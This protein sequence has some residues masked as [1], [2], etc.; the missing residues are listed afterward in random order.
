MEWTENKGPSRGPVVKNPGTVL[1]ITGYSGSGKTT[2]AREATSLLR[3][4]GYPTVFLDGDD[5]RAI[6]RNQWGYTKAERIELAQIYLRFCSY[7]A[8]Q[9]VNV[10]L[11]AAAMYQTVFDWFRVHIPNAILIYLDVPLS[12][13][14]RRD[15]QTK[16]LYETLFAQQ[17]GYDEPRDAMR[18]ANYGRTRP[19]DAARSILENFLATRVRVGTAATNDAYWDGVYR[20]TDRVP[21]PSPFAVFVSDNY[22]TS[23]GSLLE[24]GCGNG[25]D[26]AYFAQK[27]HSILGIDTSQEAIDLCRRLHGRLGARFEQGAADDVTGKMGASRFAAVYCRFVIHVMTSPEEAAFLIAAHELLESD[28]LLLIECRSINDTLKL[29]GDVISPTERIHGHYRRFIVK[30]ELERSLLLLGFRIEYAAEGKGFAIHGSEDP[31]IIRVI[32]RKVA[33]K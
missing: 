20:Q 24:V 13:R 11:S 33:T 26:S 9:G 22:L 16:N 23:A 10:V 14:V 27:G 21:P 25:R 29:L 19:S 18:I 3:E 31:V 4:S 17:P 6:L 8:S 32:A 30:E 15:Q 5:F 2:V 1:W 28:G 12:E 7:V